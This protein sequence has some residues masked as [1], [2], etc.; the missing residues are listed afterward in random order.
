[1]LA[2]GCHVVRVDDIQTQSSRR[3]AL[4]ACLREAARDAERES[5]ERTHDERLSRAVQVPPSHAQRPQSRPERDPERTAAR[6][7]SHRSRANDSRRSA[8]TQN[9]LSR[10][11]RHRY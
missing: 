5:A 3:I 6:S 2:T 9:K 7:P 4:V 10:A 1:M 8:D 11:P